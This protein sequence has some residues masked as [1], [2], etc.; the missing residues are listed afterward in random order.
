MED[1]ARIEPGSRAEWRAWLAAHHRDSKGVWLVG[2]RGRAGKPPVPYEEA[3]EEAL[4]FGWIDGQLR[5]IDDEHSMQRFSPRRAKSTWA[6][7]NKERVERLTAAGL[8]TEAGLAAVE[9]ARANGSWSSL[10]DIDNLVMPDDL[11]AALDARPGARAN[12]EAWTPSVRKMALAWVTQAK[13]SETR[14]GRV[15]R[16]AAAAERNE[17]PLE[18]IGR[19]D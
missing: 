14:A 1:E 19:R 18:A 13:R 3:V 9:L 5:P 6:R 12:Y 15:E 2:P 4:C 11:G 17:K 8:M 16:V 7:S 10:D